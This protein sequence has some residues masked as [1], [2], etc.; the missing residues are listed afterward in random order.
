MLEVEKLLKLSENNIDSNILKITP[1]NENNLIII[2][3]RYKFYLFDK[4]LKAI[5]KEVTLIKKIKLDSYFKGVDIFS[6]QIALSIP[7]KNQ[8]AIIELNP[9]LKKKL[10]IDIHSS[11]IELIKYSKTGKYLLS[12]AHD[13]STYIYD[14]KN[15]QVL[16]YL[17]IRKDFIA[18]VEFSD[19]DRLLIINYY[20]KTTIVFDML[21]YIIYDE[22]KT[23][24]VVTSCSFYK[25]NSKI[26]LI[27]RDAKSYVYDVISKE[28]KI[29]KILN[30]NLISDSYLF[31][32]RYFIIN[33]RRQKFII[34]D[35]LEQKTLIDTKHNFEV[36]ASFIDDNNLF[37]GV[38]NRLEII[39]RNYKIDE[40]K[41]HLMIKDYYKISKCID[42]NILLK[43]N[44]E[45]IRVLNIGWSEVVPKIIEKINNDEKQEARKLAYPFFIDETKE[46]ILEGY[47]V[48]AFVL[49]KFHKAIETGNLELAY[50]LAF[51]DNNLFLK[52][53]NEFR[54]LE[55][56][57]LKVLMSVK[58]VLKLKRNDIIKK[59]FSAFFEVPIKKDLINFL[60]NK[61]EKILELDEFAFKRDYKNIFL[62]VEDNLFL[63]ESDAYK[64]AIVSGANIYSKF[65]QLFKEKKFDK[66]RELAKMLIFFE[67]Y[68]D[69]ISKKLIILNNLES[70]KEYLVH[71]EFKKIFEILEREPSLFFVEE[72]DFLIEKIEKIFTKSLVYA[73]DG[74]PKSTQKRLKIFFNIESLENKITFIMKLAYINEIEK[75]ILDNSNKNIDWNRSITNYISIFGEDSILKY[76]LKKFNLNIEIDRKKIEKNSHYM[77]SIIVLN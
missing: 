66:C 64:R 40:I 35:L 33:D 32:D 37:L 19:N 21:T 8:I 7:H 60:L 10:V 36:S 2:D 63:K 45:F 73:Q 53:T 13:G 65:N 29:F 46:K 76:Y 27:F 25:S 59:I 77:D 17:P 75:N 34:L 70:I 16:T 54:E 56:Y 24:E 26:F 67:T 3:N 5:T 41:I 38:K 18:S 44:D 6:N 22:F 57:W 11:T 4:N 1:L 20:D 12:S 28:L 48:Q 71:N 42:D 50:S 47:I 51:N 15:Y 49:K 14:T 30:I 55:K 39:D 61:P 72:F 74:N 52:E 62:Y 43:L 9:N 68:R 31:K 23:Y 58:K 69:D